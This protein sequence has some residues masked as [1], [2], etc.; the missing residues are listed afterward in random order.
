MI[1]S[2]PHGQVGW[3]PRL[4]PACAKPLRR[5]QGRGTSLPSRLSS[6]LWLHSKRLPEHPQIENDKTPSPKEKTPD[7][8]RGRCTPQRED[9]LPVDKSQD[10]NKKHKEKQQ[11]SE[12][13]FSP[14]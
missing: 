9:T 11:A 12:K 6:R 3:M 5:R 8:L 7:A 14:E 10:K 1:P 13:G 4:V 2:S